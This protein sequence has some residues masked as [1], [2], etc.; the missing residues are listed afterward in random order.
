MMYVSE[1]ET[2]FLQ[3]SNKCTTA[4]IIYVSADEMFL[5][6][7]TVNSVPQLKYRRWNVPSTKHDNRTTAEMMYVLAD[8]MFLSQYTDGCV[9]LLKW[10][11]TYHKFVW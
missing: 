11:C 5:P 3:D 9:P 1:D 8:E 7:N 2:F 10:Y 4:E 6:Q